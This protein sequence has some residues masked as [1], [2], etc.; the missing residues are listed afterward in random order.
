MTSLW[1]TNT[2]AWFNH[3][4]S[5]VFLILL[6]AWTLAWKGLALYKAA[7]ADQRGWFMALLLLNTVG[8]L[9]IL[10]L[11]VFSVTKATPAQKR[12]TKK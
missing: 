12:K 7:R 5:K 4:Y 2:P 1:M 3:P 8:I 9:E 11:Y 6:L 10:Y